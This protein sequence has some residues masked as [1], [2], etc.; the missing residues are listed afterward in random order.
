MTGQLRTQRVEIGDLES[1]PRPTSDT[2]RRSPA[3]RVGTW[4]HF[5]HRE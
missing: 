1:E 4:T 3:L 5:G 2:K